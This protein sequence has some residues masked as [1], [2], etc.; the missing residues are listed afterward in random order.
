[1]PELPRSLAWL[2]P[3]TVHEPDLVAELPDE[4]TA[5]APILFVHGALH[6]AWAWQEHWMPAAAQRGWPT[7]AVPLRGHGTDDGHPVHRWRLSDYEDDVMR[8]IVSLPAPPVLVGHSMGG[9]VV[10]RVLR[11]YPARAAVL[12]ASLP[13]Y[14]ALRTLAR[15]ARRHPTDLARLAALRPLRARPDY[16]FADRLPDAEAR[17]LTDRMQEESVLAQLDLVLPRRH[18]RP[19]ADVPVLV[20]GGEEDALVDPVDVVR[21]AKAYGTQA[22][23]FRAMGH[24]LMLDAGWRAPFEIVLHWLEDTLG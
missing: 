13:P 22:R 10:Q 1:M 2:L 7:Y 12:V 4:P 19:V 20:L 21:T 14:G 6:G 15:I 18:R 8:A 3:G 11:R 24:D 5:A 9:V 16:F 23:L 17:Q